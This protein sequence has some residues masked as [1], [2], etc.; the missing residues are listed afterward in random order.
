MSEARGRRGDVRKASSQQMTPRGVVPLS[1][2][3][4]A[5]I[6]GQLEKGANAKSSSV[7]DKDDFP[8]EVLSYIGKLMP[9]EEE[10]VREATD[11]SHPQK[12]IQQLR[13]IDVPFNQLPDAICHALKARIARFRWSRM[14]IDDAVV[15][16]YFDSIEQAYQDAKLLD[17]SKDDDTEEQKRVAGRELYAESIRNANQQT[18]NGERPKDTCIARGVLHQFAN[19]DREVGWHR[20]WKERLF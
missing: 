11:D 7:L 14:G 3:I 1:A 9:P 6:D 12:F 8:P 15:D 17:R 2:R 16:A 10:L 19:G 4:D 18:F 13:L 5:D 20:D